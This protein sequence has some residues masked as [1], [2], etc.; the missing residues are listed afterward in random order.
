MGRAF[1]VSLRGFAPLDYPHTLAP[2]V[3]IPGRPFVVAARIH[4][5]SLR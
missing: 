5:P 2:K 1:R 4:T 3:H